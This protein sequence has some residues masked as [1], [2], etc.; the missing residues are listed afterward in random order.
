MS[1]VPNPYASPSADPTFAVEAIATDASA[2]NASGIRRFLNLIIDNVVLTV[3]SYGA[4]VVLG[5]VYVIAKGS[6][7][8][9]EQDQATL[10]AMGFLL[11]LIVGFSYFFLLEALCQ[12][13]VGKLLTGTK[14][15]SMDGGRPSIGQFLGRTAARY[16]PFEAFSFLT[17]Q[18]PRGW[19]DTLS[20]T[21]VI[22][23]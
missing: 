4:G 13:T 2:P 22:R 7:Q 5:I 3:L 17:S 11:G 9:T 14:V 19:H 18:E 6:G 23:G 21:R 16:I 20:G 1:Q 12:K 10:Q 15:I 8:F